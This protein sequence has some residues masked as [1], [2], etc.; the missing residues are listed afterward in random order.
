MKCSTA[1]PFL[2]QVRPF[3]KLMGTVFPMR[4]SF[5]LVVKRSDSQRQRCP[6]SKFILHP[7]PITPVR[8]AEALRAEQQH[9]AR[10]QHAE[11]YQRLQ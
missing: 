6:S 9:G 5:A 1:S 11:T 3:D 10:L 7:N 4:I 8:A 2:G